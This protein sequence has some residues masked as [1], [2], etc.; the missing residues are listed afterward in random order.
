MLYPTANPY[1]RK[2]APDQ[3]VKRAQVTIFPAAFESKMTKIMS[4][5]PTEL[6]RAIVE[7]DR[8][9]S[10]TFAGF[11]KEVFLAVESVE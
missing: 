4:V 9:V 2:I 10:Y 3:S 5:N 1:L 7:L 11:S 8:A 6:G